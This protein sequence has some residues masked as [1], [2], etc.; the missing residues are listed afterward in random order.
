MPIT[1]IGGLTDSDDIAGAFS[2]YYKTLYNSVDFNHDDM[3][4]LYN[5]ERDSICSLTVL[6]IIVIR[7]LRAILEMLFV[8]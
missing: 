2:R 6:I 7:L 4:L 3:R 5:D 1:A 8:N